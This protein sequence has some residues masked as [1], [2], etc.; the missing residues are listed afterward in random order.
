MHFIGGFAI[1]I[2]TDRIFNEKLTRF[3]RFAIVTIFALGIGAIGEI[4]E[5]LGYGVLESGKDSFTMELV[6]K[7]NGIIQ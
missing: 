6:M 1:A 7:G 4:I 5:W 2:I 3:K